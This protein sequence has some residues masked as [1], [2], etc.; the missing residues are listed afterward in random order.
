MKHFKILEF[1]A[2]HFKGL[3]FNLFF[4]LF[5]ASFGKLKEKFPMSSAQ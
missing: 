1:L 5:K 4:F 2:G 3:E